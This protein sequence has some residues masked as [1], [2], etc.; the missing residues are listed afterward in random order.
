MIPSSLQSVATRQR[1]EMS[2]TLASNLMRDNDKDLEEDSRT[3]RSPE[4]T[5][6]E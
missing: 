6:K 1:R 2:K 5:K 3:R 4:R